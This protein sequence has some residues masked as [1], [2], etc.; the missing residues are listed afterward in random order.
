MILHDEYFDP[1]PA[2]NHITSSLIQSSI[3]L[4]EINYQPIFLEPEDVK[5]PLISKSG[6]GGGLN[7]P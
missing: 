3:P 6:G 5:Q 1:F 7:Q 2:I 4:S